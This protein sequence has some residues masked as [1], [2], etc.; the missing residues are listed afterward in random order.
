[1]VGTLVIAAR[2]ATDEP[3]DLELRVITYAALDAGDIDAARQTAQAVLATAGVRVHWR[4]C[5]GDG[6]TVPIEGRRLLVQLLPFAKRLTPTTSGEVARDPV[7]KVSTVLVY[8]PRN[9]DILQTIRHS[10]RGRSR[11]EL[12]TLTPGHVVGLTIAHEV[13]HALGLRHESSGLMKAELGPDDLIALQT[14]KLW[15]R[16]DQIATMRQA[17][18][19]DVVPVTARAR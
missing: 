3:T 10:S 12:S 16:N 19:A 13:G 15:F 6:C 17:L 5:S 18:A 1:M 14:T 11:P 8:V 9:K 7:T 4:V 2:A